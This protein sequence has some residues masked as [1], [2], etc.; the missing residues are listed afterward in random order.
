MWTSHTPFSSRPDEGHRPERNT[1]T[2]SH[3]N[4]FTRGHRHVNTNDISSSCNYDVLKMPSCGVGTEMNICPQTLHSGHFR[5]KNE[6]HH[7]PDNNYFS[8]KIIYSLQER[9]FSI[10]G[11]QLQR[12]YDHLIYQKSNSCPDVE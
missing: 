10:C 11:S 2:L 1:R 7:A 8:R 12:K 3:L 4:N 9:A 6:T 5:Q